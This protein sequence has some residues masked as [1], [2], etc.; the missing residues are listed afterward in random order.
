MFSLDKDG[1][2]EDLA[3]LAAVFSEYPDNDLSP[4]QWEAVLKASDRVASS[5]QTLAAINKS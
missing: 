3:L 4:K 5:V 1:L 2:D